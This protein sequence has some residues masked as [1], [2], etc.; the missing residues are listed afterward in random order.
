MLLATKALFSG[1]NHPHC[2]A[3]RFVVVGA[4]QQVANAHS[5]AKA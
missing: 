3:L 5:R 2:D 1:D 4:M